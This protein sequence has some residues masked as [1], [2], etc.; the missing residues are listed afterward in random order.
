MAKVTIL[1]AGNVGATAAQFLAEEGVADIHLIDVP[2]VDG[3]PQGKALDMSE[4]GPVRGYDVAVTGSTNLADLKGSDLIVSTAGL[5]RKPG[6]SRED[7]VGTNA[8]IAE[9]LAKA[10]KEYA[11]EAIFINVANPLDIICHVFKKVVGMPAGRIMGMAGILDTARFRAFVGMEL[12]LGACDVAAMVLGGHGDSMV[13]LA[14]KASVSGV[15]LKNLLSR[16]KIDA[17]VERTRK[18]GGEIVALL[19]KGSA[20]YAPGAAV[21]QM[22]EAVL[23]DRRRLLPCAACLSGEYGQEGIFFGVPCVLGKNGIERVIEIELNEEEKAALRKSADAVRAG[24][25]LLPEH[26]R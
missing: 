17:I 1:G 4:A 25:A 3:M 9:S 12:G 26:L 21:T 2:A 18:G 19:K 20:Y 14:D 10:V 16:E 24:I 11:P 13:P 22:V 23:L 6:M 5:P 8:K 15:P 7:L